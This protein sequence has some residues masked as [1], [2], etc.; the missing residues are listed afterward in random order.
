SQLHYSNN[1][2]KI[3]I[4]H[5]SSSTCMPRSTTEES[6]NGTSSSQ[7]AIRLIEALHNT[8][9]VT[10]QCLVLKARCFR[11]WQSL[12][13]E[14]RRQKTDDNHAICYYHR[15]LLARCFKHWREEVENG[16]QL[17]AAI[18]LYRKHALRK[19]IQGLRFAVQ[20]SR[21]LEDVLETKMKQHLLSKYFHEW[22]ER[23]SDSRENTIRDAFNRWRQFKLQS[24]RMKL[25][26]NM[27]ERR[28]L[29]KAY[30]VWK[31]HFK[32]QQQEG[33]A[34]LHYKVTVLGKGWKAWKQFTTISLVRSRRKEVAK[35][36]YEE[37]LLHRTFHHMKE[38]AQ[39]SQMAE[40]F[41]RRRLLARMFR[42]F[43][44]ASQLSKAHRLRVMAETKEYRRLVLLKSFFARWREE[45]REQRANNV[46]RKRLESRAFEI[47]R[48]RWRRNLLHRQVKETRANEELKH[49]VLQ[50]WLEAARQQRRDR[51]AAVELLEKV[52]CSHWLREWHDYTQ[53]MVEMRA[54]YAEFVQ[55]RALQTKRRYMK[56]WQAQLHTK[57]TQQKAK[58]LWT[59]KCV[60]RAVYKWHSL[61]YRRRLEIM[62]QQSQPLRD[63]ALVKAYLKRWI[64]AKQQLDC[65]KDRA[66][67]AY[68]AMQKKGL[69]RMFVRW[70]I[71][72]QQELT[73]APL[74]SKKRRKEIARVFDSWRARVLT[75]RKGLELK[76]SFHHLQMQKIFTKWRLKT[77]SIVLQQ[78][79]ALSS[80]LHL[81]RQCFS[82]WCE[83]VERRKN[84]ENFTKCCSQQHLRRA[85][86]TWRCNLGEVRAEREEEEAEQARVKTL[87]ASC[88]RTWRAKLSQQRWLE[89][90]LLK[91]M[92]EQHCARLVRG[93]FIQW[94]LQYQ[95][96]AKAR[97]LEEELGQRRL[98][99]IFKVWQDQTSQSFHDSIAQFHANMAAIT[100]RDSMERNDSVLSGLSQTSSVSSSGFQS[101]PWQQ[102]SGMAYPLN[103]QL[104]SS[105]STSPTLDGQ[106][107]GQLLIQDLIH[108]GKDEEK[109][110]VFSYHEVLSQSDIGSAVSTPRFKLLDSPRKRELSEEKQKSL[111]R[112]ISYEKALN[113]ER[114]NYEQEKSSLLRAGSLLEPLNI[115]IDWSATSDIQELLVWVVKRWQ[116]WPVSAA[117]EQWKEYVAQRRVIKYLQ[118]EASAR[119]ENLKLHWA[120][121]QWKHGVIAMA[122]ARKY[123]ESC[124]L[125]RCF[126]ALK[127]Y[128]VS[129]KMKQEQKRRADDFREAMLLQKV[130]ETWTQKHQDKQQCEVS[131]TAESPRLSGLGNYVQ[132]KIQTKSLRYCMHVW[133]MRYTQLQEVKRYH[134]CSLVKRCF[135]G[136]LTW[137]RERSDLRAKSEEFCQKRLK[138]AALRGWQRRY[139]NTYLAEQRYVLVWKEFLADILERWHFWAAERHL[140]SAVGEQLEARLRLRAVAK[141]FRTW[142]AET[143]K[144]Q[145]MQKI[146]HA[147]LL[148]RSFHAWQK[149]AQRKKELAERLS[150]FVVRQQ[151][152]KLRR[153][154]LAWKSDWLRSKAESELHQLRVHHNVVKMAKKWKQRTQQSRGERQRRKVLLAMAFKCWRG[155]LQN[156]LSLK[157][158]VYILGRLWRWKAQ[159][160]LTQENMALQ[161]Q[162]KF[163]RRQ[164]SR[165][166]THWKETYWKLHCAEQHYIDSLV[167]SAFQGWLEF[168]EKKKDLAYKLQLYLDKRHTDQLIVAM[169]IWKKEFKGSARRKKLLQHH[170]E[171]RNHKLVN[172]MFVKWHDETL[173]QRAEKRYEGSVLLRIV[174]SWHKWAHDKRARMARCQELQTSFARNNL[175]SAFLTWHQNTR[176]QHRAAAHYQQT[177]TV[178]MFFSWLH[179]V[180]HQKQLKQ[181]SAQFQQRKTAIISQHAFLKWKL[182]YQVNM[183]LNVL[184]KQKQ[185][186]HER[187]LLQ[188]CFALWIEKV[189]ERQ[190]HEHYER[191]LMRRAMAQWKRFVHKKRMEK[192]MEGDL[193]DLAQQHYEASLRK[194]VLH[195]WC[196]EVLVAR[197]LKKRQLHL[198]ARYAKIWK[199]RVAMVK[200]A[201]QMA[202]KHKVDHCWR[203]WRKALIQS[204]V[205]KNML[206]QDNKQVLTQVFVTWRQ[207]ALLRS[208]AKKCSQQQQSHQLHLTFQ[209]WRQKYNSSSSGGSCRSSNASLCT[210]DRSY[211]SGRSSVDTPLPMVMPFSEQF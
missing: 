192:Q 27:A 49:M 191:V 148:S 35:I 95:G 111:D 109:D 61:V 92:A 152:N 133:V 187:K 12:V 91:R 40:I 170:L 129:R 179:H 127:E 140:Q 69:Q 103:G 153:V 188:D 210:T 102:H 196:S 132:R 42:Q 156:K 113:I 3:T 10:R 202:H 41:Y 83:L 43:H 97:Y 124:L 57:L 32:D 74:K 72:T 158:K 46:A 15:K 77:Q 62:L 56:T 96:A 50:G 87:L 194:L 86:Q 20:Q 6:T 55:K 110:D 186:M 26:E 209:Q 5:F 159:R 190:A 59:L 164:L 82:G 19:G 169:K 199:Q 147:S 88:L 23:A 93:C 29:S 121:D 38:T 175:R 30:S 63:R 101:I 135:R 195:A 7:W 2:A 71:L 48:L 58:E 122:T 180:R 198:V 134:S 89:D 176:V 94:K 106:H 184:V 16:R 70:R 116:H 90:T 118:T 67:I 197:Q 139:R 85:F 47:W 14:T 203:K 11:R 183:Q 80:H 142:K 200:A 206:I 98:Q 104:D 163:R 51:E 154:F 189:C 44:E 17:H 84:Y 45:L 120:F 1:Y 138:R 136:W 119:C 54:S 157:G 160:N 204:Q 99:R 172:R 81:L 114:A 25:L 165:V 28:L 112:R 9:P 53:R 64:H 166:F 123:H 73:I 162:D 100:P 146:Y 18:A 208:L 117:F 79:V 177:L 151:E 52:L 155:R 171:E 8:D 125:R 174:V 149:L 66:D 126:T 78:K 13:R 167:A 107:F 65:E 193:M 24:E 178:R 108:V 181:L 4:D 137:T 128:T 144:C 131:L 201:K 161:L 130:L 168:T 39:K 173:R 21:H 207:M 68:S 22:Q 185:A 182:R 105:M 205:S 115:D 36:H 211:I 34:A 143:H 150:N 33:V 75:K 145:Q 37:R 60:R 76:A 141:T 31:G